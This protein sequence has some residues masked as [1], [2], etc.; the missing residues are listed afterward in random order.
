[1]QWFFTNTKI[2]WLATLIIV[3]ALCQGCH[4]TV[5]GAY[6]VR[7]AEKLSGDPDPGLTPNGMER[8]IA[9]KKK[10]ANA[11]VKAVYSTN[12]KRTIATAKPLAD[13]L[14]LPI[15]IY[16][17]LPALVSEIKANHGG[18]TVLIVGH[19]N[20]VPQIVQEFGA[21]PPIPRIAPNDYDEFYV[22]LASSNG[23]AIFATAT[24]GAPSP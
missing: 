20:T 11:N 23:A 21:D 2:G 15:T 8:A 13:H 22:V 24:Y 14:G 17:Q 4:V 19:S 12:T 6:V 18:Q 5:Y 9:L 16:S 3:A 7:H 10:L 1:M